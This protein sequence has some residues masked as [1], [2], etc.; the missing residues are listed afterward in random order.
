MKT[1]LKLRKV[2][3]DKILCK[4]GDYFINNNSG[5]IYQVIVG[6]IAQISNFVIDNIFSIMY[7]VFSLLTSS[8]YLISLNWK[9]FI[10]V[11]TLQP[12]SIILQFILSPIITRYSEKQ[13][14]IIGEYIESVQD[15]FSNPIEIILSGLKDKFVARMNDKM[16]KQYRADKEVLIIN[17][18][19][20][21]LAELLRT[22]TVCVIIGYGGAAVIHGKISVG[23]LVVFITYSQKL[24]SYFESLWNFS[25]DFSA[26]KPI[27][28]RV[29][30]LFSEKIIEKNG[31]ILNVTTPDIIFEKVT[32]SYDHTREIYN[33]LSCKFCY[34]KNYG[35]IGKTGEGKST[36]IKLV[37]NLWDIDIGKI[38][39]GGSDCR[40]ISKESISEI[41]IYVSANALIAN[42]TIYNNVVF[43]RED[44]SRNEVY[45]ALKK[46]CLYDDIMQM[47]L[48][49]DTMIGE[50]GNSLS[51]GQKQRLVLARAIISNKRIIVLDEPTS[52]LDKVT[53]EK[54]MDGIYDAFLERT[55]IIISH[56]ISILNRCDEV[57]CLKNG[58]F[59]KE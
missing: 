4:Q 20:S 7:I 36:F 55:L 59:E 28:E 1:E 57:L 2:I 46:V 13:R 48:G 12:L 39:L 8:I 19:S 26:I 15:I 30:E 44:A 52:A 10:I 42:D 47:E 40:M 45:E 37:Y 25:I 49:I 16:M 56:D 43:G 23:I 14:Y 3:A 50:K 53:Q 24:M 34:G 33:E 51:M 21:H 22:M 6:D 18:A 5:D 11:L 9:L 41:L 31:K 27:H 54:V 29:D 38:S 17:G 35:I 58:K 32:F